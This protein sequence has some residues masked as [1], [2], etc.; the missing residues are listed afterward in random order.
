MELAHADIDPH[1][2]RAGIEKWIAGQA[3]PGDVVV[4]GQVLIGDADVDVPEIDDVAEIL[5]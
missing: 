1:Q 5:T 2:A 3:Q 4:R